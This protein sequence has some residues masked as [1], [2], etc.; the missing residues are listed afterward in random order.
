MN[1]IVLLDV[2]ARGEIHPRWSRLRDR[3]H[4]VAVDADSTAPIAS[5]GT[6]RF[7]VVRTALHDSNA[8]RLLYVTRN[9]G[10]SSLRPPNT[11]FLK[12]FPN[13]ARFDVV[14]QRQIATTR[15][16]SLDCR[17]HFIKVDTQ[18]SELAILQGG[19][20]LLESVVGIEIEVEFAP[21]YSG[22]A[23][24]S[25]VDLFLRQHHFELRDLNRFYWRDTSTRQMHLI[26][27]DALYF[28]R[29]DLV[30][31]REI[32]HQVGAVY[33]RTLRESL[34]LAFRDVSRWFRPQRLYDADQLLNV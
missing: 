34:G 27:A 5:P 2:G 19:A 12:R 16:D 33:G 7:E 25:D 9:P 11:E 29:P 26:F 13:P 32:L 31:D 4:V 3:L 21:L 14:E 15:L 6:K 1:D 20:S 30:A 22:Q 18:G 8:E 23:L 10:C 24:F 28:K 17:P